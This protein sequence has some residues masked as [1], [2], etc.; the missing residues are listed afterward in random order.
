M[1][2]KSLRIIITLLLVALV[3]GVFAGCGEQGLLSG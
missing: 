1:N 2:K 3:A